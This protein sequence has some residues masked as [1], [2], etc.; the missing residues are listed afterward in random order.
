[1]NNADGRTWS[2]SRKL[3]DMLTEK[4]TPQDVKY[5]ENTEISKK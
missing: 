4:H 3:K 1:M 2:M 5:G